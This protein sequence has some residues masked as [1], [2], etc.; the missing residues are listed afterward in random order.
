MNVVCKEKT[1]CGVAP[2]KASDDIGLQIVINSVAAA[3][4]VVLSRRRAKASSWGTVYA[5]RTG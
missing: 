1:T 2:G 5:N 3:Q 4:P